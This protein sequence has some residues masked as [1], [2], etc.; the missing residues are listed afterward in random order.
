MKREGEKLAPE[1]GVYDRRGKG[2]KNTK[3]KKKMNA[4]NGLR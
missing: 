1:E 3:K 4:L 2:T